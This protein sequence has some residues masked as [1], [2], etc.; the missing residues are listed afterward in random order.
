MAAVDTAVG[1]AV[2]SPAVVTA[3]AVIAV[4]RRPEAVAGTATD[5]VEDTGTA[6]EAEETAMVTAGV[7]AETAT[8]T[9][10][11]VVV[12]AMAEGAETAT[13]MAMAT[14]LR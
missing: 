14:S 7:A 1:T 4:A 6:E 9:V 8:G 3:V 5:M 10:E 11:A 12:T 2:A 13:A